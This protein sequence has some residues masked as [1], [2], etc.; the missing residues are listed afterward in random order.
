MRN[1]MRRRWTLRKKSR[2]RKKS[3][4]WRKPKQSPKF[5]KNKSSPFTM[6]SSNTLMAK[7]TT[8]WPATSVKYYLHFTVRSQ[9]KLWS[10]SWSQK[11]S[12]GFS[13]TCNPDQ[14]DNSSPKSWPTNP[15]NSC[16]RG[17]RLSSKLCRSSPETMK[18]MSF[19]ICLYAFATSLRRWLPTPRVQIPSVSIATCSS[20]QKRWSASWTMLSAW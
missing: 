11:T 3:F 10:M 15:H 14:S 6:N 20:L 7:L 17:S 13:T 18:F 5:K 4:W 19:A 2:L 9:S 1:Q 8:L 16:L 12:Q